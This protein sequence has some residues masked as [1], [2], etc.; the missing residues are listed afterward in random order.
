M[1]LFVILNSLRCC[2]HTTKNKKRREED[3]C[4]ENCICGVLDGVLIAATR[5]MYPSRSWSPQHVLNLSLLWQVYLCLQWSDMITSDTCCF[6]SSGS[7]CGH[8][9]LSDRV[10]RMPNHLE[11]IHFKENG[12]KAAP[13]LGA[14]GKKLMPVQHSS[15]SDTL[16]DILMLP[17]KEN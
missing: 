1:F 9:L 12:C 7:S 4:S 6:F 11:Q 5:L 10:L 3:K 14:L 2:P 17:F 15:L 8:G 16:P 13:V